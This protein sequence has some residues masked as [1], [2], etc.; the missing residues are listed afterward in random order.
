[1]PQGEPKKG[2]L[3]SEGRER[4]TRLILFVGS[5]LGATVFY[6][7]YRLGSPVIGPCL[8]FGSSTVLRTLSACF[9]ADSFSLFSLF[10][11]LT[12]PKYLIWL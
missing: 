9:R 3:I 7:C 6:G 1:V 11:I 8:M 10:V 12:S 4:F 2:V 5:G